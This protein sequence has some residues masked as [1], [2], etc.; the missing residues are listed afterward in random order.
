MMHWLWADKS[1]NIL[2]VE[3]EIAVA[4][5]KKPSLASTVAAAGMGEKPKKEER[6]I[7]PEEAKDAV[8]D[9]LKKPERF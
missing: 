6:Q 3:D 9:N 5:L 8:V 1:H 7:L 2:N 4:H